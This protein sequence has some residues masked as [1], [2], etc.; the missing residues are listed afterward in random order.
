M[1][2][3]AFTSAAP[4]QALPL[5]QHRRFAAALQRIGQEAAIQPVEHE[6]SQIGQVLT[7]KRF[8]LSYAPRG[9]IWHPDTSPEQRAAALHALTPRLALCEANSPADAATLRA[10]GYGMLVTGASVAELDIT[11]G[12]QAMRARQT[13]KWRNHL[14][15]AES[16][17][18]TASYGGLNTKRGKRLFV[19]ETLQRRANRYRAL[20]LSLAAAWAASGPAASELQCLRYKGEVVALMLYLFHR[21]VATYHIGWTSAQGRTTRAHRFGLMAMA[22]RL[23]V[24]GFTQIDLGTLD[25]ENARGLAD[26]K[27]GSGAVVRPLGGSWLRLPGLALVRRCSS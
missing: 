23:A 22:D 9:P 26:F 16:F 24:R 17:G 19:E 18:L 27:I 20:P 6:G 8:G 5:Q 11:G 4:K 13:R 7:L 2:F 25:S 10:A 12:A 1:E 14:R 3:H 15:K 21:P